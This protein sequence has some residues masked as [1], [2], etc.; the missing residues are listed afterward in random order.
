MGATTTGAVNEGLYYILVI[1]ALLFAAIVF[2][3]VLFLVRYRASRHPKAVEIHGNPWFEVGAFVLPTLIALTFFVVSLQGYEFLRRVPQ[4][5]MQVQVHERQFVFNFTYPD[6]KKSNELVVPVGSDVRLNITSEDVL[7]GFYVPAMHIQ[8][9]A[10]P[11]MQT[12]AWFQ[13]KDVG[14]YDILCTVY[15]GPGH[16]D[17]MSKIHV[18]K[19]DDFQ[20]WKEGKID[21]FPEND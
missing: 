20:K 18:V 4:G 5:A 19:A 17:M 7:H 8:V 2:F 9:D 11:G 16:S 6:G 1:S 15:C 10:V 3:M 21:E 13:A 12:Y 14:V